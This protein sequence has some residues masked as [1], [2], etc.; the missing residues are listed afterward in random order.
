MPGQGTANRLRLLG[1]ATVGTVVAHALIYR[2]VIPDGRERLNVLAATGH[3]LRAL[4]LGGAVL[5]LGVVSVATVLAERF[6]SGLAGGSP[7]GDP[8]W[9]AGVAGRL[10]LLQVGLFVA[11]ETI[12]RLAVGAPLGGAFRDELLL[13]GIPIQVIV[14]FAVAALLLLTGR[15][16]E[17]VGRAMATQSPPEGCST[18]VR[19]LVGTI[20]FPHG[21]RPAPPPATWPS[22]AA[23]HKTCGTC[24]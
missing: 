8:G 22:P 12:E 5:L 23:H 3:G 9:F 20:G 7:R 17:A 13:I 15:I 10:A 11:Q 1:V 21:S 16:A 19:P 6:R 2:L 24:G 4:V 14:A 18:P